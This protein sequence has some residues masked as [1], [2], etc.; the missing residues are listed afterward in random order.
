MAFRKFYGFI[1]ITSPCKLVRLLLYLFLDI[2][3][4]CS[5]GHFLE[6]ISGKLICNSYRSSITIGNSFQFLVT[7]TLGAYRSTYRLYMSRSYLPR[8]YHAVILLLPTSSCSR[9]FQLSLNPFNISNF[10]GH[11]ILFAAFIE[12]S[13]SDIWIKNALLF[14]G[15]R[16][17]WLF[18]IHSFS[19]KTW[20][21]RTFVQRIV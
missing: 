20:I 18:F 14:F 2:E 12:P 21:N 13:R 4:R 6:Q 19:C 15:A 10:W 5:I 1:H 16:L 3:K 17:Y 9:I 8:L 11:W 7:D